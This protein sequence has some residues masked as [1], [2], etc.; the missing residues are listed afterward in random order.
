MSA[1]I[2]DLDISLVST[3][4]SDMMETHLTWWMREV[5][6]AKPL[7]TF[8]PLNTVVMQLIDPISSFRK[9]CTSSPSNA[10]PFN[11]IMI[12]WEDTWRFAAPK[13][14]AVQ[15]RESFEKLAN[16]YCDSIIMALDTHVKDCSIPLLLMTTKPSPQILLDFEIS[17]LNSKMERRLQ[18]EVNALVAR[19]GTKSLSLIPWKT[20]DQLYPVE[21]TSYYCKDTDAMGHVPFT[22]VYHI[23]LSTVITRHIWT[24]MHANSTFKVI[25]TDADN[26]IWDGTVSEDGFERLII[27]NNFL[28]LQK[29]FVAFQKQ[30]MLVSVVSMNDLVEV[31]KVFEHRAADMVLKKENVVSMKVNWDPKVYILCLP[32]D[33]L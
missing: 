19:S 31:E 24:I 17:A 32:P 11:V 25:A 10:T 13:S 20:V 30:G 15:K 18:Q 28:E 27:E 2:T 26:T 14:N 22:E 23:C 8:H 6:Q 21:G 3:F 29:R 5:L 9:R 7:L 4:T 33:L 1:T 16:L 12:R